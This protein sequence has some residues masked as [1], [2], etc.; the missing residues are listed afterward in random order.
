MNKLTHFDPSGQAHMVNVGDKPHTHRIAVATG[1]ITMLPETFDMIKAG[2]HKKGDV[3]GIARIAGIQASKKTS[4][5]IP[6]CHPL[7]LTHVS[8]EFVLNEDTS[9]ITC[10]VRAETTGPTGVEMEA[11]TAVQVALLTIY[12]MAKAVDRGMV[13]GDVHLLEKSGGKSGEWKA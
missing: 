1:K 2:T 8:L 7:A 6:L 11:L 9:S 12:D 10:Q 5:L 13:M 3:L 4:D